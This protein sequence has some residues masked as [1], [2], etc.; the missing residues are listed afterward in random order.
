MLYYEMWLEIKSS[1][2]KS[3]KVRTVENRTFFRG[4]ENFIEFNPRQRERV[5]QIISFTSRRIPNQTGLSTITTGREHD[6]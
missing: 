4:W 1:G 5:L 6:K 3:Y 2:L